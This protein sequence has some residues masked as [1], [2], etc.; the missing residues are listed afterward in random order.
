MR[1]ENKVSNTNFVK[2][3]KLFI[4]SSLVG[5]H[6]NDF[7]VKESLNKSL[8]FMKFLKDF[9]SKLNEINPCK[10]AITINETYVILI[11]TKR[12]GGS[13][14]NIRENKF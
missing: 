4:L 10:I 14:P 2:G 7:L 9:R 1:T 3:V 6:D 11:T 13:T 12:F 5:L 8:K